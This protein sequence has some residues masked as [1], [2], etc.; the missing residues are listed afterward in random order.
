[1]TEDRDRIILFV[2]TSHDELG[3]TGKKTGYYLS[4]L[5]HPHRVLTNHGYHVEFVS[6]HGGRPPMD[7]SS[8]DSGDQVSETFL[9]N[10]DWTAALDA[11]L[12]PDEVNPARYSAIFFVG[13]HGTMWDLPDNH[14][15]A[16]ITA[17]IYESGGVVGAVCHGPAGLINVTLSDG[18]YL[19]EGK[20]VVS[21]SNEEEVAVELDAVVPFLLE[22]K[23]TSRGATFISAA[24][25]EPQVVTCERLVTGQ[26]PASANGVGLAIA[27]LLDEA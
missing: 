1:V 8:A 13:G 2:V 9:G 4:E 23:L 16:E 27:T 12:Q 18:S 11:S 15:L 21:F 17:S 14:L 5:T 10:A 3:G 24:P 25:F 6:P 7:P 26:N 20:T 19:V 22:D